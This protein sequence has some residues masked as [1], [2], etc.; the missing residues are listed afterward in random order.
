M[1][2]FE[3]PV[4]LD[5]AGDESPPDLIESGA[6][7]RRPSHRIAPGVAA[8]AAVVL[9]AVGAPEPGP[10]APRPQSSPVS[11]SMPPVVLDLSGQVTL[12]D[13]GPTGYMAVVAFDCTGVGQCT[14]GLAVSED[15]QN[16]TRRHLPEGALKEGLPTPVVLGDGLLLVESHTERTVRR[17]YSRDGGGRWSRV[18]PGHAPAVLDARPG[19]LV[20][21]PPDPPARQRCGPGL[22]S[23]VRSDTGRS[24]PLLRQPELQA[25]AATPFP[26]LTGR[27]WVAGIDPQ[28]GGPAVAMSSDWGRSW[29]VAR[30]EAGGNHTLY[31]SLTYAG[32]EVYAVAVGAAPSPRFAIFRYG[33]AGWTLTGRTTG[34]EP[35]NMDIPIVCADGLLLS[36]W[37]GQKYIP[38]QARLLFSPDSG[39]HWQLTEQTFPITATAVPY[40]GGSAWFGW[41]G[42]TPP[43]PIFSHDCRSWVGLPVE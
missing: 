8:L 2:E 3:R 20:V 37:W 40:Y 34:T 36:R 22:V 10:P 11:V 4:L 42:G 24:A 17:W 7:W 39:R 38:D 12:P 6:G 43:R 1:P 41:Y 27:L 23:V 9:V 13:M 19:R 30:L 5:V 28:S 32:S 18:P 35:E 21:E 15:R 16:W 31:V 29:S 14:G 26:D 33:T 25:C